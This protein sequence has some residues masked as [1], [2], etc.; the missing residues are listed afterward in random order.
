MIDFRFPTE[1]GDIELFYRNISD[2]HLPCILDS[3]GTLERLQRGR[4]VRQTFLDGTDEEYGYGWMRQPLVDDEVV[5]HDGSIFVSTAYAGFLEDAGLGVVLACNTTA[6]PHPADV[7]QAVLAIATGHDA[8]AVPAFALRRKCEAV[9]GTY[10]SF[11][12]RSPPP[13]SGPVAGTR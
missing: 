6:E 11:R 13:S 9:T 3:P 5:G 10:E 8:M 12:G 7:G 4:A 2:I 1:I